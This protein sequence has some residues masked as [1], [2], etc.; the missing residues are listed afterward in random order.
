M[1]LK[2]LNNKQ[3][4]LH[5][6]QGAWE[7]PK[8]VVFE[9]ARLLGIAETELLVATKDMEAHGNDVAEFGIYKTYMFSTKSK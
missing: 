6:E 3:Y 8:E 2:K 4:Q 7:G 5:T 9:Y 1:R